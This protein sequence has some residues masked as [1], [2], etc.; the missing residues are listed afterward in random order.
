MA[1]AEGRG[2]TTLALA[3]KPL[4]NLVTLSRILAIPPAG[5]CLLTGRIDLA[6]AL[7]AFAALSDAVDGWLA[8]RYGATTLGSWLDAAADRLLIAVVLASLWWIGALPPWI[9]TVL[10]LREVVVGIGALVAGPADRPLRPL[11]IGKA[12]T[13]AAFVLL[14]VGCAA[15][16]GWLPPAAVAAWSAVVLAT[17]L[18]SLVSYVKELRSSRA[19]L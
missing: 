3:A 5:W 9:V 8:R 12:H 14:L 10:V 4:A 16:G 17:A 13:A 15:A 2:G 19:Q 1:P 7:I 11:R 18:V 6:F